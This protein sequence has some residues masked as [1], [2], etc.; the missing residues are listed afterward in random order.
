MLV[1][2][3]QP[4]TLLKY[5]KDRVAYQAVMMKWPTALVRACYAENVPASTLPATSGLLLFPKS[6]LLQSLAAS[7]LPYLELEYH[8]P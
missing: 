5:P 3:K 8:L 4:V 1:P 6:S 7:V 2:R